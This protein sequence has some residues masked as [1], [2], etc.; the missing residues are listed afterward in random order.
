[1]KYLAL[2]AMAFMATACMTTET[3]QIETKVEHFSII[4]GSYC[5]NGD[6][7]KWFH[8]GENYYFITCAS[9]ETFSIKKD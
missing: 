6:T 4:T 9:G 8:N 2:A 1:M 3:E 7:P 5:R